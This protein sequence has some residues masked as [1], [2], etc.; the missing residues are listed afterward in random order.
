MHIKSVPVAR[1]SADITVNITSGEICF[2]SS[3]QKCNLTY[4]TKYNVF[5]N[6]I[7]GNSI[8]K[9]EDIPEST[10]VVVKQLLLPQCSPFVMSAQ[11]FNDYI[12]YES[13]DQQISSGYSQVNCM[14]SIV[15]AE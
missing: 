11:P 4:L 6:D 5:I 1:A 2:F 13:I 9:N 7:T 15:H 12:M 8:F 3:P 14:Q 10:C